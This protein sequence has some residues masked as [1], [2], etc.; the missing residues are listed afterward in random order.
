M[1][2][3]R[4]IPKDVIHRITQHCPHCDATN[5]HA[6]HHL[7]PFCITKEHDPTKLVFVCRLCHIKLQFAVPKRLEEPEFGICAACYKE[8]KLEKNVEFPDFDK[9]IT[10]F[11]EWEGFQYKICDE[12]RDH[13]VAATNIYREHLGMKKNK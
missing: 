3:S 6:I 8:S 12:C 4:Y 10:H 5:Y 7:L 13:W 11:F 2:S 1:S 9:H